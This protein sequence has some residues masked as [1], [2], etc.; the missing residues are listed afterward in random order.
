MALQVRPQA[1]FRRS[2]RALA[3]AVLPLAVLVLAPI[4]LVAGLI[5]AV[6][7]K[8]GSAPSSGGFS[9]TSVTISERRDCGP[10]A[11]PPAPEDLVCPLS[12]TWHFSAV[13]T[14]GIP[15]YDYLWSFGDGSGPG[16]GQSLDHTFPAGCEVYTVTVV[17][18]DLAGAG[19]N[20]TAVRAC[21]LT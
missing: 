12:V 15:P 8:G 10:V 21:D 4:V 19:S 9:G 14:G 7:S 18:I 3:G 20:S 1:R 16:Y 5:A 13:A 6:P 11:P 17:A 2:D